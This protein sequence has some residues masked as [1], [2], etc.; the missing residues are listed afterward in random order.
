MAEAEAGAGTGGDLQ[1]GATAGVMTAAGTDLHVLFLLYMLFLLWCLLV[2][3]AHFSGFVAGQGDEIAVEIAESAAEIAEIAVEIAE[4]AVEIVKNPA[5]VAVRLPLSS[6]A[7]PFVYMEVLPASQVGVL[8]TSN[9]NGLSPL[10]RSRIHQSGTV[11]SNYKWQPS[12]TATRLL[13]GSHGFAGSTRATIERLE[14]HVVYACAC[15]R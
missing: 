9:C 1:I 6:H 14:V 13:P 3:T 11:F 10:T 12:Q 4:I 7:R 2:A 5:G 8:Q 15:L